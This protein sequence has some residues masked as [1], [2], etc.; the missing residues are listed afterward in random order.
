MTSS[1]TG[2]ISRY[3]PATDVLRGVATIAAPRRR[4][5]CRAST[6][7]CT[8]STVRSVKVNG[9]RATWSRT[10][11]E[12]TV[13]PSAACASATT[14]RSRSA[15]TACPTRSGT[16]RSASRA[17]SPPT[18]ARRRRPA[19]RR[20][21]LVPGQRPPA[22]QGR[23]TRS[24]SRCPRGLEAMANGMLRGNRS[25]ARLDDLA[26]GRREPMA[27]Y[28]ATATIGQFN[29]TSYRGRQAPLLGRHRPRPAHRRPPAHAATQFAISQAGEQQLQAAHPHDRRAR[30]AAAQ[31]SFWVNRDTEP[32]WDFFFVEAHTV[33]TDDWTTLPDANGHTTDDTGNCVPRWLEHAPVPRALPDATTATGRARRP[34]PP[35]PGGRRPAPATATSNGASTSRRYAGKT[36]EVSL[37]YASDEA[38]SSRASASTT[39]SVT[40]GAGRPRSRPTGTRSTAGPSR[41]ARRQPG[42]RQRLDRGTVADTPSPSAIDRCRLVR[43]R[44]GDHRASSASCFGR[45]HCRG[46]RHRRRQARA[47]VRTGDP[48]ATDVRART[49]SRTAPA[50][51]DWRHRARAGAPMDRRPLA[52]GGWQDIWLNEGFASYTEWLW[53]EHEGDA[54]PQEI[55]DELR[56]IPAD[57][58]FWTLTIGDPGPDELFDDAGLR[59]RRDDAAR[60]AAA[61]SAT[62]RSSGWCAV[63]AAARRRE[64]D[65]AAVHRAGGAGVRTGPRRVL[66]RRGCSPR[67]GRHRSA[68]PPGCV[69]RQRRRSGSCAYCSGGDRRRRARRSRRLWPVTLRRGRP[70][71]RAPDRGTSLPTRQLGNN[72]A[73][74]AGLSRASSRPPIA[75][76]SNARV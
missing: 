5:T 19:A 41:A 37:C 72:T 11:D 30:R 40:T 54:T 75:T 51:N 4:R 45:T 35:A 24:G 67:R 13:T 16:P 43:A 2:S 33:G 48:D 9:R 15:T 17:S 57:D 29:I 42:Q 25:R 38:C 6:S 66:R 63:G 18:T 58:P 56:P 59:P 21:H 12:L 73:S 47:R 53:A 10:D 74:A 7:T 3:D 34:A 39:W 70:R 22:G 62:T 65:H 28:L 61:A 60:A 50:A 32:D 20:R 36:V 46:R 68:R 23:R 71:V 52:L 31:L 49:S 14:S 27:S 69:R 8:G 26:V 1:T 64:R 76:A 44:A 55:F